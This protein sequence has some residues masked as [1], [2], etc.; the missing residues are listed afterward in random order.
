MADP[1][2]HPTTFNALS[3][4]ANA[5]KRKRVLGENPWVRLSQTS[6]RGTK[7]SGLVTTLH[8]KG[9]VDCRQVQG[10]NHSSLYTTYEYQVTNEGWAKLQAE[11][12]A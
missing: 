8:K 4:I 10:A 9:L 12:V 11:G 1:E 2:L 6:V 7:D 3:A 5:E